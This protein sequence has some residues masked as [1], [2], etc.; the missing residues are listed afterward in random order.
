MQSLRKMSACLAKERF[1]NSCRLE[2]HFAKYYKIADLINQRG[3]TSQPTYRDKSQVEL[4]FV[5]NQKKIT[6]NLVLLASE[7]EIEDNIS[8]NKTVNSAPEK[9]S[10]VR[11]KLKKSL[12]FNGVNHN[13]YVKETQVN[14]QVLE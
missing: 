1:F 2:R 5:V 12:V 14:L 9:F 6:V 3:R 4:E 8:H 7:T 11:K 13:P 10:V